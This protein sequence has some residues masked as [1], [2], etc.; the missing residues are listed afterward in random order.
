M[1]DSVSHVSARETLT[2]PVRMRIVQ[3]LLGDRAL[4]TAQLALELA[5][6]PKPTL[7][8]HIAALVDAGVLTIADER[9]VRGAV[10]RTYRLVPQAASAGPDEI[11]RM[12]PAERRASFAVF[13]AGLIAAFDASLPRQDD[14]GHGYRTAAIY[15]RPEDLAEFAER[16]RAAVQPWLEPDPQAQRYLFSTVLLPTGATVDG[17]SADSDD[18]DVAT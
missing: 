6:I 5:D 17:D 11:V 13:T 15:L 3:S 16:V 1:R 2:H 12:S 7:Y 9:R 18:S 10:E 8:R 14:S 4:T